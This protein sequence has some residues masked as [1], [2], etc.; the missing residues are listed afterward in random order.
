M[1]IRCQLHSAGACKTTRPPTRA[2]KRRNYRRRPTRF[3]PPFALPP[4][5]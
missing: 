4:T 2:A 3:T 5:L 1:A